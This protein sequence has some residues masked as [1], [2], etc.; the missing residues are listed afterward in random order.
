MGGRRWGLRGHRSTPE[1]HPLGQGGSSGG[2]ALMDEDEGAVDVSPVSFVGS[3]FADLLPLPHMPDAPAP[4][5]AN[6]AP[7]L[8]GG[9]W[10]GTGAG[11]PGC[12][13]CGSVFS[14]MS[15]AIKCEQCTRHLCYNCATE[16]VRLPHSN[17]DAQVH[18][19]ALSG[20][21]SA[22]NPGSCPLLCCRFCTAPQS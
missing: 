12:A 8:S 10:G 1:K 6:R 4:P 19:S 7:S 5:G 21:L 15:P 9:V 11:G 22:L 3:A 17:R 20:H 18:P 16:T 2:M 13:S 14:R